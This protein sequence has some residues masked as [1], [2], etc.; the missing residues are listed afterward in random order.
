MANIMGWYNSVGFIANALGAG[1]ASVLIS[2][3]EKKGW[4]EVSSYRM[5]VL[6]YGFL[7]FLGFVF[8]LMLNSNAEVQNTSAESLTEESEP[9]ITLKNFLM[10]GFSCPETF[11]IMMILGVL[12]AIDAF[13]GNLVP[14]SYISYWYHTNW[15]LSMEAVGIII[16]ASN[17]ISGI[18]ALLA[19]YFVGSFGVIKVLVFTHLPTHVLSILIPLMPSK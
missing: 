2:A 7:G 3:L 4:S 17:I 19:S 15:L 18:G 9:P 1:F 11:K 12:F 16:M 5:I 8:Y 6:A 14:A 10:M 13:A